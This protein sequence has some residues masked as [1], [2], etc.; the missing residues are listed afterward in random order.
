[1]MMG[2]NFIN[3]YNKVSKKKNKYFVETTDEINI[4]RLVKAT[5]VEQYIRYL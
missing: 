5:G 1:M 2:E 3:Y 4:K